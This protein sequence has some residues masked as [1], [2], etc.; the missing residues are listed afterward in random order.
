MLRIRGDGRV[1]L[2]TKHKIGAIVIVNDNDKYP[3]M[4]ILISKFVD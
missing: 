4:N 1:N 3:Q 2:V